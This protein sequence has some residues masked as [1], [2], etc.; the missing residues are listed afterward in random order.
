M[1]RPMKE[2]LLREFAKGISAVAKRHD[3][4]IDPL[5]LQYYMYKNIIICKRYGGSNGKL[6]IGY[7]GLILYNCKEAAKTPAEAEKLSNYNVLCNIKYHPYKEKYKQY[8]L[9]VE[10]Q[11]RQPYV[12]TRAFY[13]VH[14]LSNTLC[15]IYT[16]L[17]VTKRSLFNIFIR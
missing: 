4:H 16:N 8:K 5:A 12:Y 15:T 14:K 3:I 10:F 2:L 9:V 11:A 17:D 1:T 13:G 7:D 6:H